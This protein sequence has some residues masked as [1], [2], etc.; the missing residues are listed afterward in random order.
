[1]DKPIYQLQSSSDNL[2]FVFES[3]SQERIIRKAVAYILSDDNPDLY[4]L[5]FGDLKENGDID[6]LSASNNNDMKQV[7]TTVVDTLSTFF[8]HYPMAT[9]AFTGSTSSR[10]R[11]YRAAITQF[12]KETNLYYDVVGI[13]ENGILESF[14]SKGNYVGYLI[15]QKS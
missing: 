6:I 3:I 10:T 11:L 7:L 13:T 8:E 14:N 15:T 9:V 1:M 4:Q 5:I 2:Q 12:L